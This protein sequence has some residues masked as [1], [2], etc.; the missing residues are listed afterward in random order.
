MESFP[1]LPFLVEFRVNTR[2]HAKV[3]CQ[4]ERDGRSG[5]QQLSG[6]LCEAILPV[7]RNAGGQKYERQTEEVLLG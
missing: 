1:S 4:E 2:K 6:R 7:V 3:S 5:Y